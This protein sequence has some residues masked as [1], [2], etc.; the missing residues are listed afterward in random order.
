MHLQRNYG[1]KSLSTFFNKILVTEA[2]NELALA[3]HIYERAIFLRIFDLLILHIHTL[4]L[5]NTKYT[6]FMP[7][8]FATFPFVLLHNLFHLDMKI[9]LGWTEIC[10]TSDS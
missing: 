6:L 1:T 10:K 3:T 5:C 2:T 7:L 8:P 9:P 4:P